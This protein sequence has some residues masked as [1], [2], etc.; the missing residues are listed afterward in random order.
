MNAEYQ[1]VGVGL[2]L[3]ASAIDHSC[4]PNAAPSFD[5]KTLIIRRITKT[6][7]PLF[8]WASSWEI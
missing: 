7:R 4:A 6:N 8:K 2:Y 3:E 5:G 1:D